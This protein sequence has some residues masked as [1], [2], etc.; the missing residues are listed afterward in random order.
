MLLIYQELVGQNKRHVP[1]SY[2][3]GITS[4]HIQPLVS[5]ERSYVQHTASAIQR[6]HLTSITLGQ[7]LS[8]KLTESL[9]SNTHH[10]HQIRPPRLRQSNGISAML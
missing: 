5:T 4:D 10:Y 6:Q 9:G 7:S 8:P 1:M 2:Y 3:A